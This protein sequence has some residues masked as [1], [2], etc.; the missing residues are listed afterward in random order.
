MVDKTITHSRGLS[1]WQASGLH[2][3]ISASIAA[4]VI[5]VMLAIWYPPPLFTTE[6]GGG[7]LFILIAVDV[8]LGPLIT[9]I[10]FKSGK[11]GLR[12]DLTVIALLQISALVY[13]CH[14]M[15]VARPV[16]IV[17]VVDQFETV[18]A[19]ELDPGDLAEAR[20][21]DYRTLPL[22]GPV[23]VAVEPPTDEKERSDLIF[24]A[25]GGGKDLRHFPKYY[26][27]YSNYRQR[28]IAKSQSLET[29]RTREKSLAGSIEKFI[30]ESGRKESEVRYLPLR[31]RSGWG[32]A[33]I[34]AKTGDLIKLLPPSV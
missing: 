21:P 20:I 28:A 19:I 29:A 2:L 17:F 24:S 11:P 18:R 4:V 13:G 10:I 22:T 1:R 7:I 5:V 3:L 30:V 25:V 23:V 26:V 27:I 16:F 34:D 8:V 31:T 9:L 6:G 33:L 12:M 32:A 15:F 14:V